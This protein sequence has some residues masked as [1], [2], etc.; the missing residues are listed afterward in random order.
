MRR[1]LLNGVLEYLLAPPGHAE[2]VWIVLLGIAAAASAGV[3]RRR[4]A[5]AGWLTLIG[6]C[7]CVT[8][9]VW[10]GPLVVRCGIQGICP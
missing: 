10:M 6:A 2:I 1:T 4:G 5:A 7:V 9:L 3:G 8:A